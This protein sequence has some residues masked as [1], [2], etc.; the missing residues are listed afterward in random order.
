[1]WYIYDH[2]T[3]KKVDGYFN[4]RQDAI[5]FI[6]TLAYLYSCGTSRWSIEEARQMAI[7]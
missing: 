4:C 1:M 5:N 3:R 2:K 6:K 7:F